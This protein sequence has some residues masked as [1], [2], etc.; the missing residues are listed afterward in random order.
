MP[1]FK[2]GKLYLYGFVG[3][4]FWDEGFTATDVI[5]ALLEHGPGDVEAHIN[6]GGG[7]TDD[8][9]A[10]YNAFVAHPGNV[11]IVVDSVAASIASVIA[12]AGDE[13]IMLAGSMM[14][15]H[16]PS[17][18]TFGNADDHEV[19]LK[20]LNLFAGM[21]AEIYARVTGDHAEDIRDEMKDELWLDQGEAVARGFA[22]S[23]SDAESK[24]TSAFDY[25]LF[26]SA[27]HRLVASAKKHK[28]SMEMV[29]KQKSG[30]S[31]PVE[32][33][34]EGETELSKNEVTAGSTPAETPAV[35]DGTND[36]TNAAVKEAIA[37]DRKRRED[38]MALDEAKG[39]GPLAEH[40]Y[41]TALTLEEVQEALASAAVTAPT[42]TAETYEAG[43]EASGLAQPTPVEKSTAHI[44]RASIF[45][46]RRNQMK[47]A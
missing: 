44:N 39:R 31:A 29:S 1:V 30:A 42:N 34:I 28:W 47:G 20:R 14:M 26:M 8:G 33:A 15:I 22:T 2:D 19:S 38:I 16:D 40:L 21:A 9:I 35:P 25:R 6:S 27:P 10:I 45:N 18:I 12:M 7:Y 17:T 13:R 43:R 32:T 36:V 11:K 24:D 5:D 23:A 37:A 3:E 4:S 46:A 41:A